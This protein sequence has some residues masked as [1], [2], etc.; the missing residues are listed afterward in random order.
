MQRYRPGGLSGHFFTV[1]LWV[2]LGVVQGKSACPLGDAQHLMGELPWGE[3]LL[4]GAQ[5]VEQCEGLRKA[6]PRDSARCPPVT[7]SLF[8]AGWCG[9]VG[10]CLLGPGEKQESAFAFSALGCGSGKLFT[11]AY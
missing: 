5:V 10:L 1:T 2:V 7:Q 8:V 4:V 9:R 11:S 6:R 3:G